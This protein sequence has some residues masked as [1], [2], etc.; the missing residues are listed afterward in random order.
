MKGIPVLEDE[1]EGPLTPVESVII[2]SPSPTSSSRLALKKYKNY[3]I[4]FLEIYS[5]KLVLILPRMKKRMTKS[6]WD[7]K[8]ILRQILDQ[9]I[10]PVHSILTLMIYGKVWHLLKMKIRIFTTGGNRLIERFKKIWKS[11]N[12]SAA[13]IKTRFFQF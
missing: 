1:E 5:V 10:E 9:K 8:S 3:R 2:R 12:T 6:D 4:S 13:W 11:C 7:E